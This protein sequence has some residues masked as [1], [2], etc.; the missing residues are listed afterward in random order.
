MCH[1]QAPTQVQEPLHLQYLTGKEQCKCWLGKK[2]KF[3]RQ[4][5]DID[6]FELI[7]NIFRKKLCLNQKGETMIMHLDEY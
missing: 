5:E 3:A 4:M 2:F 7:D 1:L 6:T